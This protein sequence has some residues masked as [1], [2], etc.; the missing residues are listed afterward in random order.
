MKL[1]I[2]RQDFM[3]SWRIAEQF[4]DENILITADGGT[5]K[6]K[7]FNRTTSVLC[8]AEGVY[9]KEGGVAVVPASILGSMIRKSASDDFILDTDSKRGFFRAGE[10]KMRFPVVS[11]NSFPTFADSSDA[12]IICEID[13]D[14]LSTLILEGSS[15]AGKPVDFPKYHGTSFLRTRDGKVKIVSTD[16]KRLSLSERVCEKILK[17]TS[18]LMPAPAL[19]ELAKTLPKGQIIRISANN[20]SIFF[21]LNGIEYSIR[22][23][24]APFPL[25]ERILNDVVE[26]SLKI[27]TEDLIPVLERVDIIAGATPTHIMAMNLNPNG[28]LK[29][30]ARAPEK[31]TAS[32]SINAEISGNPMLVGFNVDFFLD[33]LKAFG[34]GEI[35][36][37][38]S[39][40]ETQARMK[41][42]DD[43]LYMLMPA[44]LA[45]QDKVLENDI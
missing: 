40:V 29:I 33:G 26:T 34:N 35:N 4:S 39:G 8:Y 22:L 1:E 30:T 31:G 43:F 42:S 12:E 45:E 15:A 37:E 27:K 11:V 6:L 21:A 3:K 24:D 36:I 38:F 13:S 32:E 7:A 5:T 10:S 20:A 18:L 17:D 14:T 25:Y 2:K 19:K 23:I 9:V 41:R 44:R 28:E 16:G